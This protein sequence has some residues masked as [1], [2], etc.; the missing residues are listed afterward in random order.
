MFYTI[1]IISLIIILFCFN[2]NLSH[3]NNEQFSI[4]P[5]TNSLDIYYHTKFEQ[6]PDKC[7]SCA[8]IC[9]GKCNIGKITPNNNDPILSVNHYGRGRYNNVNPENNNLIAVS[10]EACNEIKNL[11]QYKYLYIISLPFDKTLSFD[12]FSNISYV[13]ID[14]SYPQLNSPLSRTLSSGKTPQMWEIIP[15]TLTN[16]KVCLVEIRSYSKP[17]YYLMADENGNLGVS[18]FGG[19]NNQLWE[20]ITTNQKSFVIKSHPFGTFLAAKNNGYTKVNSGLVYLDN[21]NNNNKIGTEFQWKIEGEGKKNIQRQM[22]TPPSYKPTQSVKDYPTI[23]DKELKSGRGVWM[24]EFNKVWNGNYIFNVMDNKTKLPINM[25][26]KL[27]SKDTSY[28]GTD[29]NVKMEGK[30]YDNQLWQVKSYGANILTGENQIYKIFLEMLPSTKT[31]E[32][33]VTLTEGDKVYK[34]TAIKK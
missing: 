18:L 19:S 12:Y 27:S 29:G 34:Y 3:I 20:I 33:K 9:T 13:Y 6:K 14:A 10:Q 24:P 28:K 26:I 32:I 15:K 25:V 17:N 30:K 7:G 21:I 23:A 5:S 11:L 4:P 22:R 1:V 16:P 31:Q 2:Y 8:G